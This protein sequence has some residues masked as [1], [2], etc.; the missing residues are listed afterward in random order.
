MITAIKEDVLVISFSYPIVP[1]G[2][3]RI[4]TQ[5]SA[6]QKNDLIEAT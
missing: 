5:I 4:R 2:Q 3:D 6:P 1:K